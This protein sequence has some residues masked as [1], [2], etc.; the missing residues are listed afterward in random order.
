MQTTN[1][2]T[3]FWLAAVAACLSLLA[4]T[5]C[6]SDDDVADTQPA[7]TQPADTQ[8]ADTEPDSG[9]DET[10]F[11]GSVDCGTNLDE[12]IAAAQ[13][14]GEV[15]FYT[16][17]SADLAELLGQAFEAEYGIGYEFV[18]A[19]TPNTAARLTAED[20][21]GAVVAD[22][23]MITATN[24]FPALQD[25]GIFLRLDE[26]IPGYPEN[27]PEPLPDAF[28]KAD[29]GTA[30]AVSRPAVI[31]YNTDII[32]PE[33]VPQ[34][35]EDLADPKYAHLITTINPMESSSYID[36]FYQFIENYGE[37]FLTTLVDNGLEF[38]G[39]SSPAMQA[40][41]AGETGIVFGSPAGSAFKLKADGAPVDWVT[42]DLTTGSDTVIGI[43][44]GAPHPCAGRLLA[45]FLLTDAGSATLLTA[46]G[47]ATAFRGELPSGYQVYELGTDIPQEAQDR[48]FELLGVG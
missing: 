33:D 16:V 10:A 29:W 45:H 39:S 37:E 5:A 48:I 25:E 35:H 22:L 30:V 26:E 17:P 18:R 19:S 47:E 23:A 3:K 41:S 6:G 7:D 46:E 11:I 40:V 28:V 42:P 38:A 31:V 14:E 43:V 9:S 34:S 21:A 12:L 8:P 24:V 1:R 20:A 13:E 27:L 36:S 15:S 44:S 4:A 32:A 2:R